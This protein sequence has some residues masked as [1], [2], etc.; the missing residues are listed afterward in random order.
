MKRK[1]RI[2][3]L[4]LALALSASL[5]AGNMSAAAA[6]GPGQTSPSRGFAEELSD[7]YTSPEI[8]YRTEARWW[9]AEGA[10]T[11]ETLEE[12]V[13]GLYDAGFRGVELCQ[14]NVSGLDASTYGY[15]SEQW[16]HDFH[17][18]LNKALD[19]G[20]TVGLTS[21]TNWST[22]NIPGLDPD[23]QAANQAVFQATETLTAGQ[24]RSGKVPTES[25]TTNSFGGTNKVTLREKNEFIGAYAYRRVGTEAKPIVIDND[26]IVDLSDLV[27]KNAK[28]EYFLDWTAPEDGDYDVVYYWQVGTAQSSDPAVEKSYCINYFDSR[29]FEALKDYWEEHVLCDEELNAKIKDGDVQLFMDSLEYTTGTGFVNWTEDFAA[30]FEARK[31]Y[32]IRPYLFLAIGLP[33]PKR[34]SPQADVYGTYNLE[35]ADLGQRI[36]NDLNDVQTELYMENLMEPFKE[37]LHSYGIALRAQISYGKYLE[38]SEPI[39]SVDYP[40]AETLN[41]ENQIEMY[42]TWSGGAKLQNKILSSETSAL[43]GT[44]YAYDY[45]MHLQEA[46]TLYAAG[47]SRINWHIWTSQWAPESVAVDWPGFRSNASFNVL[48]LRYPSYS[49]YDEFNDHLGRVQQLLREGKSRSDVGMVYMKYGMPILAPSQFAKNDENNWLLRHDFMPGYIQTTELQDNGY[50]YDYF[51]PDFLDAEGVYYDAE[52]GTLEMAGYKALVLWQNWLT[53]DGAQKILEYAKQGLKV[54]I[55]DGA[56]VQTPYNDGSD[57]A[58]AQVISELKTLDCV[59]AAASDDEIVEALRSLDVSPYAGMQENH[60]L[61]TQVRQDEDGNEYL[62]AYNYCNGEFCEEDHGANI[63]TEITM[64]GMFIPYVIDAWSGEVTEVANYRCEAG[65]TIVPI[66]LN[67]GDV[68]LYAFEKTDAGKLHITDTNA[69]MAAVTEDGIVART[70]E[71]GGY[72][73]TA[74]DGRTVRFSTEVPASYDITGWDLTVEKWSKGEEIFR[75]E[76]LGGVTTKEHTYATV[77]TDID[78]QLD[79]LTTWDKIPEVGKE[80]CGKGYYSAAFHWDGLADGA[81]IDFGEMVMSMTV[82]VNGQQATDLNMNDAK[83]DISD[84]L[85]VGENTI[86]L[87]YS[88]NLNNAAIA[89]GALNVTAEGKWVSWPGYR[90]DYLGYGPSQAVVVPYTTTVLPGED[91]YKQ[92]LGKLIAAAET[93]MAKPDY[94]FVFPAA[95]ETLEAALAKAQA[96]YA[97]P[98]ASRTEIL[99]AIKTLLGELQKLDFKAADT[100][101]LRDL[102]AI[103]EEYNQSDFT[104]KSW[105]PFAE[106]M[107]S[108]YAVLENENALQDEVDSAADRLLEAMRNLKLV[109][110]KDALK[111]AVAA[112]EAL[113]ENAYSEASFAAVFAAKQAGEA[114]LADPDATQEEVDAATQKINDAI[115]ALVSI[116]PDA[117]EPDTGNENGATEDVVVAGDTGDTSSAASTGSVKTGDT[118]PIAGSL[119]LAT[120]LGAALF[121]LRRKKNA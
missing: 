16:D 106:A 41:Q 23:S 88:S 21:G 3:A 27:S 117:G 40:E 97:E 64:D 77:K 53:L 107:E 95:K 58:L 79:S 61:L 99:E 4:C 6:A 15:G 112:A 75:T 78:V 113:K 115:A 1:T 31:G 24:S 47:F 110:T 96:V 13:Q 33:A 105:T 5:F 116:A 82:T 67:Y 36:L 70:T 101:F 81:Y 74:S 85:K 43:G 22:A 44:S 38:N 108:A 119:A 66:A 26:S 46:Y 7:K 19:L 98:M 39:Q 120:I 12:E 11:D 114:V 86:E 71:S 93:E 83:I 72:Y 51:S 8:E 104:V 52:S 42:R 118:V 57:Q 50:T 10:H 90:V 35:D 60:Q 73:A 80:V 84:Y 30:E 48:S 62:Y 65:K 20:M 18:V 17:L 9:M 102:A 32:D 28:G 14:L 121:V 54:V 109:A 29:G 91:R 37:W 34:V 25:I 63:Q 103:G 68:A 92:A 2:G 87:E 49:E 100:D 76:T 45:Q 89:I 59:A 55:V 111:D 56:A 69:D 94:E